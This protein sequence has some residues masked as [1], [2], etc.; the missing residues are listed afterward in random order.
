MD[1]KGY[2]ASVTA[3]AESTYRT[4]AP[5]QYKDRGK[6]YMTARTK[7]FIEERAYLAGDYV[8]ADVQ[9]LTEDFYAFTPTKIRLADITIRG[10]ST[11]KKT[12][13]YKEVLFEDMGIDYFPFGAKIATMGSTWI[14]INPYNISSSAATAIVQRCNTSY[15]SF[16]DYGNVITEPIIAESYHMIGNDDLSKKELELPNG[17]F[18]ISCQL[19][20]NTKKLGHNQRI[21]LGTKAYHITG[22]TDFM[23]EFSGDRDS[24]HYLTF[25]ARLEE[26]T[27]NDDVDVNFIAGGK[28]EKFWIDFQS[29]LTL[30]VPRMIT[31]APKFYHNGEEKIAHFT[32]S[33]SDESVIREFDDE[34]TFN[35]VGTGSAVI[36]ATLKE[37]PGIFAECNVTV[38]SES[39]RN[40]SFTSS[41]PAKIKQFTRV[42]LRAAYFD[43]YETDEPLAWEVSGDAVIDPNGKECAVF[44]TGSE[45]VIFVRAS[46]GDYHAEAVMEAEGY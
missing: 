30:G 20:E 12:D 8:D 2:L 44:C 28:E 18:K 7:K 6:Q 5:I 43:E 40:V 22:F 33:S 3:F 14:S 35:T 24:C 27:E 9:G 16:D 26:P 19:N 31:F 42:V 37:N 21:I 41:I 39:S 36:R 10:T 1:T 46:F 25:V 34:G 38:A 29:E 32:F 4:N 45:S 11:Q 23:Q 17:N 13:D 15:N